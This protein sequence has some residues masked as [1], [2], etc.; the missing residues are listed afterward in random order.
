[1]ASEPM[2]DCV[3]LSHPFLVF[4]YIGGGVMCGAATREKADEA[5]AAY[6]RATDGKRKYFG[7]AQIADVLD[8]APARE[9]VVEALTPFATFWRQWQRQP[10]R[11]MDDVVY[12]IH[13]GTE[14]E[15]ELRRSDC[16]RAD[17]VL[18]AL[19]STGGER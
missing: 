19:A 15:A 18:R 14:Y 17:R 4:D 5:C 2:E 6:Q 3:A 12:A 8:G 16:E 10:M 1:M 7:V 13:T 9:A 11:G